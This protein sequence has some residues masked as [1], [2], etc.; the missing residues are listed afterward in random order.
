VKMVIEYLDFMNVR[1]RQ[2]NAVSR[3]ASVMLN[4]GLQAGIQ[5]SINLDK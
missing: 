3:V 4:N 5:S 1:K 2:S